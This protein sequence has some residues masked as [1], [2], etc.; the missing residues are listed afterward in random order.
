MI[1]AG[2][3]H[4]LK[5]RPFA[6]LE[7]TFTS[8]SCTKRSTF[9]GDRTVSSLAGRQEG[10]SAATRHGGVAPTDFAETG[11]GLVS[12]YAELNSLLEGCTVWTLCEKSLPG[13]SRGVSTTTPFLSGRAFEQV[14]R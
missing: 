1:F 6:S 11:E 13:R 2:Y 9:R 14:R 12:C 10:S 4:S 5:G 7:E 8:S 3:A